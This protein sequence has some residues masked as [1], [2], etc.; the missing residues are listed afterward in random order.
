[1]N[2][3]TA[4]RELEPFRSAVGWYLPATGKWIRRINGIFYVID[5]N[6]HA[7]TYRQI[8]EMVRIENRT[9]MEVGF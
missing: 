3:E 8:I 5:D 4:L 1:M 2:R 6:R 7:V 9:Q